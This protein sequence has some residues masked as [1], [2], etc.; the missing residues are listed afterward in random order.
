[1]IA[2]QTLLIT[3]LR[4]GV[5]I[6]LTILSAFGAAAQDKKVEIDIGVDREPVWYQQPWAW[7][8]GAAI[9]ILLLVALLRGTRK[10]G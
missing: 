8:L 4:N 9:F 3:W 5:A 6:L 10:R 1:M 7:V 2:K